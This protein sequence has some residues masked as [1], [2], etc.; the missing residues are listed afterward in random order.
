M[1]SNH[2][3]ADFDASYEGIQIINSAVEKLDATV[4]SAIQEVVM[5]TMFGPAAI[6]FRKVVDD[7]YK[8]MTDET[9]RLA[10]FAVTA[11]QT[12]QKMEEMETGRARE[13]EKLHLPGVQS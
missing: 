5:L 4:A 2:V 7:W 12:V 6:A 1:S 10:T 8:L 9:A 13:I 3:S 11:N